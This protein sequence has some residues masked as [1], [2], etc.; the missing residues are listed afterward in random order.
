MIPLNRNLG[1]PAP[2]R[3]SR[4]RVF[5]TRWSHEMFPAGV[6]AV[7]CCCCQD[8][9][10]ARAD[11]DRSRGRSAYLVG[12]RRYCCRRNVSSS[13][14]GPDRSRD[15]SARLAI[16]QCRTRIER[17]AALL[18]YC[19]RYALFRK[20]AGRFVTI[21][22]FGSSSRPADSSRPTQAGFH[23]SALRF[24]DSCHS[25]VSATDARRYRKQ[26]CVIVRPS[27]RL[28]HSLQRNSANQRGE[29]T[30]V[31]FRYSPCSARHHLV[32]HGVLHRRQGSRRQGSDLLLQ[33]SLRRGSG[34]H[35]RD[36][37]LRGI[38]RRRCRRLCSSSLELSCEDHRFH[39]DLD[40]RLLPRSSLAG[41][42]AVCVWPWTGR[43]EFVIAL[44]V[45]AAQVTPAPSSGLEQWRR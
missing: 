15:R 14:A 39:R 4:V 7:N 37:P 25:W 23:P 5:S 13:R 24:P 2:L 11:L 17:S 32:P 27:R 6:I 34:H 16:P 30:P 29:L 36:N 38:A 40:S 41:L 20:L 22:K 35:L 21:Q 8:A 43:E 26:A 45:E 19:C 31:S 10:S 28:P 1:D 44:E 9:F 33:D 18:I 12:L 3:C 42:L